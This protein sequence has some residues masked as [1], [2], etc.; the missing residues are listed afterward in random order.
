MTTRAACVTI[1]EHLLD[2]ANTEV[3]AGRARPRRPRST[4]TPPTAFS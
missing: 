1:A 3:A 2:H 4:A